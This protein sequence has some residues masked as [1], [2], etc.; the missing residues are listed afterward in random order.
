[1]CV[2]TLNDI[3]FKIDGVWFS[4]LNDYTIFLISMKL[5]IDSYYRMEEVQPCQQK[6]N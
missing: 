2:K 6:K 3:H 4:F 5:A 1:M